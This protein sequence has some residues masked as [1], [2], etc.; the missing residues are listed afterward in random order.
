MS[1]DINAFTQRRN[2]ASETGSPRFGQVECAL[3]FNK[4]SSGWVTHH[5][6]FFFFFHRVSVD[7][8]TFTCTHRRNVA[9]ETGSWRSGEIDCALDFNKCLLIAARRTSN[10]VAHNFFGFQFA[11]PQN[12][13]VH[14]ERYLRC[15]RELHTS[16]VNFTCSLEAVQ[17]S[18]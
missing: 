12:S 1:V 6:F 3:D 14:G 5:F 17:I 7:I 15:L 9:S 8:N 4:Y 10:F 13:I 11:L 2:V 18:R 16:I